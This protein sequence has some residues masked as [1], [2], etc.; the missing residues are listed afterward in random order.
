MSSSPLMYKH[1]QLLCMHVRMC[2]YMH[3]CICIHPIYVVWVFLTV[4]VCCA[5]VCVFMHSYYV[6]Q[7]F[8]HIL[9]V[10]VHTYMHILC[11]RM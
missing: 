8:S 9:M 6:E 7:R 2:S 5:C 4:S 1:R 3:T 11:I 10:Y